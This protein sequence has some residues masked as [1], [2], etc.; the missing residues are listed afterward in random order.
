MQPS[1]DRQT[2]ITNHAFSRAKEFQLSAYE[3]KKLFYESESSEKPP[4]Y[5]KHDNKDTRFWR[6]GTILFV[7]VETDD[8]KTGEPIYLI[9]TI[10]DQMLNN[11][12]FDY[13]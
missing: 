13:D 4:N 1:K 5:K 12:N 11:K 9:V 7:A 6:N 10:H 3:V 2:R 8:S